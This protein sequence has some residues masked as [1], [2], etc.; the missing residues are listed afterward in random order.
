MKKTFL[1]CACAILAAIPAFAADPSV[2]VLPPD[3]HGSRALEPQTATAVVRDYLE[4]WQ[5]MSAALDQNQASLLDPYFVGTSRDR[6]GATVDGQ[7][8]YGI[9]THYQDLSHNLQIVFYSPDGLS[10]Q[11][12]DNVEYDE[13]VLDH[14][15]VLTTQH[16]KARY[17]V[18]LTPA[19]VR[20]KIRVFQAD[21]AS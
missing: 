6:L 10:I 9:H 20:W 2:Q 21:P 13:Q 14:D 4:S 11:M 8:K 16:I 19:E 5:K 18:V 12:S 7:V 17:V 15:K 1:A 3:L